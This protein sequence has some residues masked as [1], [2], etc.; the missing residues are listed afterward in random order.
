[1]TVSDAAGEAG[2][3]FDAETYAELRKIAR[4][5]LHAAGASATGGARA[6]LDTTALVHESWLRLARRLDVLRFP[7]VGHFYAYASRVM[8]SV[9]V[10]LVREQRAAARDAVHVTLATTAAAVASPDEDPLRVD[11]ALRELGALEPRLAQVVEMRYYGGLSD[12]EIAEALG[13]TDR[14]VRR[15]WVKARAILRSMLV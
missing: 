13:L 2:E 12:P 7:T 1:M 5:R 3:R 10:D 8:R 6:T 15:D 9:V 4:A 14:T 11:E